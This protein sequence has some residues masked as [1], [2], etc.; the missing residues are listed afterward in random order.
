MAIL[1][2]QALGVFGLCQMHAF[3]DYVR[4]KLSV[5]Q[6]NILFRSIVLMGAVVS[7]SVAAIGTATGS[8]LSF[9]MKS[10]SCCNV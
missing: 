8:I 7:L 5:E 1:L 2:L 6:F 4:S 3:I 9:K 10:F